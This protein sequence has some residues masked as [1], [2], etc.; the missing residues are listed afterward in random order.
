ME[1][2]TLQQMEELL[3][4]HEEAEFNMDLD[5]TLVTLV[6]NP[7]Y[8]LPSIGWHIEGKEAVR[9]TYVRMMAGSDI[10]NV[11]ADKRTHA[12]SDTELCREAYV[13][14]D[15]A[16]GRRVTGQYFVIIEFA[17]GKILG[18]RMYMD[19]SFATAMTEILGPDFGDIPGVSKL[20]DV[21][22]QPVPRL[23]RAAAHAA[24]RH[25]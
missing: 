8:E 23:D 25:H 3:A 2:L 6:D 17:D 16:G 5:A 11:W 14:F 1:K 22:P 9:E 18:E 12:I 13:Y 10:K 20:A 4:V 7:V 24:D 19:T 15:T 21:V